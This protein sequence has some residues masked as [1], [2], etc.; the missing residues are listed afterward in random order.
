MTPGEI[1]EAQTQLEA[2]PEQIEQL[3]DAAAAGEWTQ[4]ND[5]TEARMAST[6]AE[7]ALQSQT[8]KAV[9]DNICRYH[10]FLPLPI[11]RNRPGRT[12]VQSECARKM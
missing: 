3:H 12:Q 2:L 4:S 6:M 1:A 7:D 11:G 10:D 5:A 8:E 9:R